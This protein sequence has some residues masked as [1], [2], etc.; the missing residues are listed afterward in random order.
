MKDPIQYLECIPFSIMEPYVLLSR[1]IHTPLYN[2][3]FINYG[4]NK[5]QY[6]DHLQYI[7]ILFHFVYSIG[8]SFHVL[9]IGFGFDIPH[10]P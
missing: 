5:V 2:E 10:K 4:Y 9:T 6:I 7:G 8:Y 3:N 1:T